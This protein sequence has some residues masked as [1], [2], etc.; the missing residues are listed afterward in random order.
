MPE[1]PPR[2]ARPLE[3][4]KPRGSLLGILLALIAGVAL[5][6]TAVVF[7]RGVAVFFFLVMLVVFGLVG[8]HYLVW[9]WWLGEA[10][11]Q[12]MRDEDAEV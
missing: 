12:E 11:R 4:T 5:L 6:V 3:P 9:G 8:F 10:L 1:I 7:T 2:P